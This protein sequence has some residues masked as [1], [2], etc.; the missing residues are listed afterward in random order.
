MK[1]TFQAKI[2][3]S[4]RASIDGLKDAARQYRDA[5]PAFRKVMIETQRYFATSVVTL[6]LASISTPV[7]SRVRAS[8]KAQ[9]STN[10]ARI[11]AGGPGA[12]EFAGQ[13]FGGRS[14]R[15]TMQFQPHRGRQGYWLYPTVRA[16]KEVVRSRFWKEL[17]KHLLNGLGR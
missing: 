7:S 11:V 17:D 6:A 4:G 8:V 14:R 3:R 9:A 12:P 16:Q 1:V 13:E 15:R 2:D 5:G 10:S